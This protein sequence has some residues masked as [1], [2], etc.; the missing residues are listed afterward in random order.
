[1]LFTHLPTASKQ[2]SHCAIQKIHVCYLKIKYMMCITAESSRIL[3]QKNANNRNASMLPPD[4]EEKNCLCSRSSTPPAFQCSQSRCSTSRPA[5]SAS[6]SFH[7]LTGIPR[8][9]GE[10]ITIKLFHTWTTTFGEPAACERRQPAE[11]ARLQQRG[12]VQLD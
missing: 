8:C 7:S 10:T 11:S 2:A 6:P 4:Q 3:V 9:L 1:M 5:G 12:R